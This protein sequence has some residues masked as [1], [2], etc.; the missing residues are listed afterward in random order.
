MNGRETGQQETGV[1]ETAQNQAPMGVVPST[2][3]AAEHEPAQATPAGQGARPAS[4]TVTPPGG[5][6][7]LR[8]ILLG[9]GAPRTSDDARLTAIERRLDTLSMQLAREPHA[10]DA[11]MAAQPAPTESLDPARLAGIEQRLD[12]LAA[13]LD[14]AQAAARGGDVTL[15]TL[16]MLQR[17]V[18]ELSQDQG[19]LA[20][21]TATRL[22]AA[23]D[24]CRLRQTRVRTARRQELQRLRRRV[25]AP[26]SGLSGAPRATASHGAGGA[27][28]ENAVDVDPHVVDDRRASRMVS[29]APTSVPIWPGAP[30]SQPLAATAAGTALQPPPAPEADQH[31]A[32]RRALDIDGARHLLG[33][34]VMALLHALATI[35]VVAARLTWEDLRA[36]AAWIAGMVR[37]RPQED[38]QSSY[39]DQ[40]ERHFDVRR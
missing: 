17:Q 5:V 18:E 6:N 30:R 23:D 28:P 11:P 38:E 20:E 9:G 8:A 15:Q 13:Q 25:Y 33:R 22:K 1:P 40:D 14:A 26:S 4:D 16:S 36:S 39:D 27:G 32:I 7:T 35:I 37:G 2:S 10:G 12:A 3:P 31:A 21:E 24:R 29:A 34:S 19:R